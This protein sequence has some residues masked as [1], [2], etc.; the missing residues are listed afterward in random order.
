MSSKCSLLLE[1]TE[2][3]TAHNVDMH[4]AVKL[5]IKL[6]QVKVLTAL[7]VVAEDI[8]QWRRSQALKTYLS[9][10]NKVFKCI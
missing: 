9:F 5:P 2:L 10:R 3:V 6:S 7:K 8:A 4:L 1:K